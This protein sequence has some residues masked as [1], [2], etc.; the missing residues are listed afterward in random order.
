MAARLGIWLGGLLIQTVSL[1]APVIA[2]PTDAVVVTATRIPEPSDQIPADISLIS[3]DE[4]VARGALDIAHALSLVP[5]VEAPAG[6]DAGPSSAVPSFWGLHEFDAFLLVVDGI[7]WGGAFNPGITTLDFNNLERVE[8]LKGAAPVL[9]GATS[10]EG[11]FNGK[12]AQQADLAYGDFG[13]VRGSASWVLPQLKHYRQSLAI[14]GQSGGFADARERVAQERILY[15]GELDW[16][17]GKLRV[18][19]DLSKV[20]DVPASPVIRVGSTLNLITP[21]NANF[22][23]ADARIDVDKYHIA[24]GYSLPIAGGTWNSLASFAYSDITDIRAFLHADLSGS[25]DTQSQHRS[26]D[27]GYLDT[28]AAVILSRDAT[29]IAGTDL[30]YGLGRQKTFNGNAAF[31][32]PLNG[33][34]LPP[35]TSALQVNEIG[36]ITDRRLFAGQYA[37]IDWKPDEHWDVLSGLRLNE[38]YE[39]KT[40]SDLILLPP[41][42]VSGSTSKTLIRPSETIG[43]SYRQT[44]IGKAETVIYAD[45]RNAF[46]PS[47]IDFGPDYRPQLLSPET[48]QS[49]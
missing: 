40:S 34:V 43:V 19:A 35:V 9:Y 23:P 12:A 5:G 7:P 10:G 18:D 32:L 48:A 41:Q 8:V 14:S 16:G 47:A 31:T 2:A 33:S 6:G 27:D 44:G 17:L 37:Q 26:I 29:L 13:S 11:Y 46:K 28:H 45:Y 21:I 3:D 39:H 15:R 24:V 30:L 22:N 4:L 20:R 1:I 49:Y 38:T 42:F 36:V 25:A